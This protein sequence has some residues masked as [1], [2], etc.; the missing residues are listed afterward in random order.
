[1]EL[2]KLQYP[3]GIYNPVKN[4][5]KHLLEEWILVIDSFP[6]KVKKLTES[7]DLVALNWRYR[8]E[9]WTIKQVVHHCADSHMNAFF[10]FKL[11]L[12]ENKPPIK[13]YLENKWAELTD[14][15]N[16]D[17]SDSLLIL[18]GLHRKW[19]LLLRNMNDQ[20]LK[21]EFIHPEHGQAYKLAETIGNYAW[22][23][24]HHLAHINNAIKYR[25]KF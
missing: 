25:G 4:P 7:L 1:M 13:P 23:S 22:H 2:E 24:N 14:S 5:S 12:T 9:G 15:I 3:V 17:I 20:E 6:D 19:V 16:D 10:R 21:R 8:P 11:A 18:I